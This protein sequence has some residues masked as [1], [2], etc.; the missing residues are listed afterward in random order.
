MK[1]LLI[2]DPSRVLAESLIAIL[3]RQFDIRV[4]SD[5]GCLVE[6]LE[7]FRPEFLVINPYL[8]GCDGVTLLRQA[9]FRPP[10][11]IG[12]ALTPSPYIVHSFAELGASCILV[13]PCAARAIAEHLSNMARISA[14]PRHTRDPRDII[15]EHLAIL[16][17]R[18][19]MAGYPQLCAELLLYAQDPY[20]SLSKELHPAVAQMCDNSNGDQVESK[21]RRLIADVWKIR[22]E[23]IWEEYFPTLQHKPKIHEFLFLLISK[24][25]LMNMTLPLAQNE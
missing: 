10:H 19:G 24:L 14:L 9:S 1:K 17:F 12:L 21:I 22:N 20:Q 7:S 3:N 15:R 4:C 13:I 5:S 8:T 23:A 25:G 11:I 2:V 16:G 6:L 18:D